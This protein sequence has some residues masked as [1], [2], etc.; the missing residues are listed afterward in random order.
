VRLTERLFGL[1]VRNAD[2]R[3]MILGDL[4]EERGAHGDAWFYGQAIGIAA[5]AVVR[6]SPVQHPA[7]SGDTFMSTLVQ[8]IR[9]GWRSLRKRPLVT[10]T[11]AGTL[12]LGLGANAAIFNLVD[13]LV[14][15][16]FP[17][18]DPDKVVM[19]AE[20][21]PGLDFKKESVSPANFL[22]WRAQADTLT[23][24][25]GLAWWDAN[26]IEKNDPERVQGYFASAGF[27]DALGVR[28]ALGRGFVQDD[29]TFGRHHVV[30]LSDGLWKRRFD[31]DPAILGRSVT[32]DGTPY[33]V[34]GVAPPRFQFPDGASLWA[35]LAFDPK[36]APKRDKRFLTVVGHLAPGRTL[37]D[38]LSQMSVIAVRLAQQYPEVNR[39]HG[40][41]VYTLSQG[42][43]DEGT[44]SLLSMWQASALVVL[45]IA[46]ANIA[47]LML[48]RAAERQRDVAVRLALG[49]SRGR[50][51]R[52]LLTESVLLACLAVGPALGFAWAGLYL[53]RV[54]MPANIIRFVPGWESIGPDFRL[55]AFTLVLALV[56]AVIFGMLPAL[57]AA[58]S[59]VTDA[60]KE[61][62]R[63]ATGRQWLRRGIVVTEIAIALPLLVTAGL[64]VIGTNRFLNG[65]QGYDP[66]GLLTMKLVLPERTYPDDTARRHFVERAT[67]EVAAV[68][69]VTQAAVANNPPATG[70]NSTRTIEIDGHPAPDPKNLP[71]VDNRVVTPGFLDVMRIPMLRGRGFTEADREDAAP[72]AIVSESMAR[73]Y[74]PGEEPLGRRLRIRDGGWLTVVG[75]C[76]DLIQD[77]FMR[78]NVPTMYRPIAQAPSDYFSVIV[79]TSADP[80]AVAGGVRAALL[81]V[82]PVQPVFDMMTMRRQLHERTIGLQYL[83]SIM[84]IFAALGLILAAVGLYAVIAYFV[85]QRRHEIGLRMALGATGADVVRL[86]IGQAVKLTSIGTVIGLGLSFALAR[87][88]EAALLGIASSDAGVFVLF[89]AVLMTTALLAGYIPARRAASIDPMTALRAE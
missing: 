37:D 2:E 64:G 87:L 54:A 11:V 62:G 41:H 51:I 14:L 44:G 21:G 31:G 48:A 60:L 58:R 46:C 18:A 26:L 12:A 6:R 82:D 35:P 33:Q 76:G 22:D 19:L 56:T 28:P 30:V 15:R 36:T 40:A 34:I 23:G 55:L 20:T 72:V 86:T 73:Q 8:D 47:N 59:S 29:E 42:M 66:D 75:V 78:R 68:A 10:L 89:A 57:Q 67:R 17:F 69:G 63:T 79:R 13:R 25:S 3:D 88:M 7:R 4:E 50:I 85:A 49:A 70:A 1:A 24:L 71:K 77:W 38:A 84:A 45:L 83:A 61:G 65:P 53:M 9:Y 74:W 32:I 81:R 39:D 27:F 43:L 5:H 16:P 80:T 52:E